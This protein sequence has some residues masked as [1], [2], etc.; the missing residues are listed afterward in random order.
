MFFGEDRADKNVAGGE[1]SYYSDYDQEHVLDLPSGP[2]GKSFEDLASLYGLSYIIGNDQLNYQSS[3]RIASAGM[4]M[5][6]HFKI[7]E[8]KTN[9]IIT[10]VTVENIGIAPIYYDAYL[11]IGTTRALKSLKGL[12]SGESKTFIIDAVASDE[13]L[14]IESDAI[15]NGQ[16]IQFEASLEARV[17]STEELKTKELHITAYPNPF[18]TELNIHNTSNT[19][20]DMCLYNTLGIIV[21]CM[22]VEGEYILNTSSL[23]HGIYILR[24]KTSERFSGSK[25]LVK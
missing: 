12:L 6:Y 20:V 23:P 14:T 5:G 16:E 11:T 19:G 21:R 17:L 25:V 24:P 13:Q 15:V 7:T 10:E 8:F 3:A 9:G 1:F 4:H 22:R 2:H 18:N